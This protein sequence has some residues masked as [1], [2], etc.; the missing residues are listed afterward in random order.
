MDSADDDQLTSIA[1][2]STGSSN[3]SKRSKKP[4]LGTTPQQPITP[5]L[6][7]K[8]T[9]ASSISNSSASPLT[10]TSMMYPQASSAVS[11]RSTSDS[12]ISSSSAPGF[13]FNFQPYSYEPCQPPSS[14]SHIGQKRSVPQEISSQV[15]EP[16]HSR[17][18]LAPSMIRP[19]EIHQVPQ[20]LTHAAYT[21]TPYSD[22]RTP[23]YAAVPQYVQTPSGVWTINASLPVLSHVNQRSNSGFVMPAQWEFQPCTAWRTQ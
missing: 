23:V 22:M 9:P 15:E 6:S 8:H 5:P 2:R 4:R 13:T 17:P 18:K 10:T 7:A 16:S 19:E 1:S 21:A 3:Q 14:S 20:G 12:S 11:I